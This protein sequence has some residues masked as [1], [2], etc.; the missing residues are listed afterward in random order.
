M[1]AP[2]LPGRHEV[3]AYEVAPA[4]ATEPKVV[5]ATGG[6]TG[7]VIVTNFVLYVVAGLFYGGDA[8]PQSVSLFVGLVITTALTFGAGYYARHVNRP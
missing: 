6:A 4:D 2:D 8:I 7:G 1:T 3:A 5:A